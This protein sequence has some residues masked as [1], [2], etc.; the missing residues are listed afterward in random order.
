MRLALPTSGGAGR[1]HLTLIGDF[2]MTEP[3]APPPAE[4]PTPPTFDVLPL[5]AELRKAVDACGYTH[6]TPVQRAVFEPASRG[7]SLVVQARTGT[8]KTAAFGL[9]ILDQLV[10]KSTPKVQA[11]ILTPT[12]ELALQVAN[13]LERLG[14]FRGT[15]V[16]AIYGGA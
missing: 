3:H 7:K 9:P 15:K 13:E 1:A 4:Q 14:Q 16:V 8:G 10:K 6:P 2:I 12:R 11:L 5:S